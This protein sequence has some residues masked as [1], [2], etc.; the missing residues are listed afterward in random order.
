MNL[1]LKLKKEYKY[2]R[3]QEHFAPSYPR[4]QYRFSFENGYGASVIKHEFSYG[5]PEDLWELAVLKQDEICYETSI[6]TN[7]LGH[8][9][10]EQVEETLDK[11]RELPK[12]SKCLI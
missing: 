6:T 1:N 2:E 9:T 10:D 4:V 5:G 8:L 3:T 7:V 12:D 11:I